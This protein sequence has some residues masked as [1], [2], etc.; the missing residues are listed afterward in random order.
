MILSSQRVSNPSDK[1][2]LRIL[3]SDIL[4]HSQQ[5]EKPNPPAPFPTREGGAGNLTPLSFWGRGQ[6]AYCNWCKMSGDRIF[7]KQKL[8]NITNA[9]SQRF[10]EQLSNE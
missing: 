1:D 2:P 5:V 3:R 9:L 10:R 4:H 6:T 8:V 7:F